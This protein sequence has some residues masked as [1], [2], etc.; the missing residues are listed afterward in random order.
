MSLASLTNTNRAALRAII[1]RDYTSPNVIKEPGSRYIVECFSILHNVARF[2]SNRVITE[3]RGFKYKKDAREYVFLKKLEGYSITV[4]GNSDS[5][6]R[7]WGYKH[8]LWDTRGR[9]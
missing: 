5:K 9:Y 2:E 3:V 7:D 6:P 1:S 4:N 8:P